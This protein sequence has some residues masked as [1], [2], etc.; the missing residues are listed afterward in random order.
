MC[1]PEKA[2]PATLLRHTEYIYAADW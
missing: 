1:Q 2:T